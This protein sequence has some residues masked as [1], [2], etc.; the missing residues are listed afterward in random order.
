MKSLNFWNS[1]HVTP[2]FNVINSSIKLLVN[3]PWVLHDQPKSHQ[4]NDGE[5]I[6][7]SKYHEANVIEVEDKEAA[8]F[9]EP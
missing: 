6:A 1:S 8:E 9:K 2:I 5:M 3:V 7:C 4:P